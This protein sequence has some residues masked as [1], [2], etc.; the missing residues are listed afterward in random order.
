M[1]L[2]L[3][4]FFVFVVQWSFAQLQFDEVAS[5]KGINVSYGSPASSI[6]GAGISFV[7][8]D[9]DG[10]D[11]ITIATSDSEQI[12]FMKNNQGTFSRIF[13]SGI[14]SQTKAKQ[15]LWVDYDNDGDKDFFV[16]SVEGQNHLYNN[17]EQFLYR[18]YRHC[19]FVSG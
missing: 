14:L 5:S 2:L 18:C 15:V 19:W 3:S 9:G 16:T 13:P 7:D 1:R 8:F 4:I 10:W 11:D 6:F 12:Y 17:D